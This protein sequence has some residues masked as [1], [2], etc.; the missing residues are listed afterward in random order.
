MAVVELAGEELKFVG[1]VLVFEGFE[2]LALL[3][4]V[5][6]LA[7]ALLQQRRKPLAHEKRLPT[8]AHPAPHHKV[9]QLD[10]GRPVAANSQP[11]FPDPLQELAGQ[12]AP[13]LPE[14]AAA[15]GYWQALEQ[16]Y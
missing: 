1:L 3:L 11:D 5:Q 16:V 2:F 4:P 13:L 6:T 14:L 9:H 8:A 15:G 7:L 10:L 12:H